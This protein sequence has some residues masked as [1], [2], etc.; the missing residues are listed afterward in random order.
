M[1]R[2]AGIIFALEGLVLF[3][4][5]DARNCRIKIPYLRALEMES[6]IISLKF[7]MCGSFAFPHFCRV[8]LE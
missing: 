2:R 4:I 7:N 6:I 5:L 8:R 3:L 1:C